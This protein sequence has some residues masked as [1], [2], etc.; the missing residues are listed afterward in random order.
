MRF[1]FT[2][3][4]LLLLFWC[5]PEDIHWPPT[6]RWA[7][8]LKDPT[9]SQKAFHVA[10]KWNV[11]NLQ[12]RKVEWSMVYINCQCHDSMIIYLPGGSSWQGTCA[13]YWGSFRL[14]NGSFFDKK[15][16]PHWCPLCTNSKF[17]LQRTNCKRRISLWRRIQEEQSLYKQNGLMCMMVCN[18]F[19]KNKSK[20]KVLRYIFIGYIQLFPFV[21]SRERA[22]F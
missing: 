10:Y 2:W 21:S 3:N 1:S 14:H 16:L 20:R 13:T 22:S 6:E 11:L 5:F 12:P 19:E 18:V 15:A 4:Y 9:L 8:L 17:C 7:S